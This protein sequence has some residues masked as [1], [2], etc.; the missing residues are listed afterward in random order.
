MVLPLSKVTCTDVRLLKGGVCVCVC[1]CVCVYVWVGVVANE[2][3][4]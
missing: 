2:R 4:F 1:V 3:V